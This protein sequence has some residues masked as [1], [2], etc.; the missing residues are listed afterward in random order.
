MYAHVFENLL[1]GETSP[2]RKV[3]PSQEQKTK[4]QNENQDSKKFVKEL[5]T[6]NFGLRQREKV[7][8]E[9]AEVSRRPVAATKRGNTTTLSSLSSIFNDI[10]NEI[11][12]ELKKTKWPR[13][14]DS[15]KLKFIIAYV[16]N[17][18]IGKSDK[19]A[20]VRQL[21]TKNMYRDLPNVTY[22]MI[23]MKVSCLGQSFTLS[24]GS[25]IDV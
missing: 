15:Y 4:K 23:L 12:R 7:L 14:A 11:E 19:N 17:L 1:V 2:Q 24:N 9:R 5:A 10:D 16:D 25:K 3:K 22:D 13:L 8:A 20:I 6:L 21:Q 18:D